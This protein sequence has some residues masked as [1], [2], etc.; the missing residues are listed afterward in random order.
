MTCILR[1]YLVQFKH[2]IGSHYHLLC[3]LL[4][5]DLKFEVRALLRRVY[6]RIGQEFGIAANAD[7]QGIR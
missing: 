7:E 6:T 2:H 5:L 4:S 3:S 1:L